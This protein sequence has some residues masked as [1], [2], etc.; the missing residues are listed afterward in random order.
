MVQHGS[1]KVGDPILQNFLIGLPVAR[2]DIVRRYKVPVSLLPHQVS[3]GL[4]NHSANF[5]GE[6]LVV[7]SAALVDFRDAIFRVTYAPI[8]SGGLLALNR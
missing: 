1:H 8:L 4:A 3:P 7:L 6:L 5:V 2:P